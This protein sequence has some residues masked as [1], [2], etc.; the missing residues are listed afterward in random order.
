METPNNVNSEAAPDAGEPEFSLTEPDGMAES[1]R[2]LRSR[3]YPPVSNA[4]LSGK[5]RGQFSLISVMAMIFFVALGL[6]GRNWMPASVFAGLLGLLT[7]L[8]LLWVIVR[9]PE[10]LAVRLIWW[11]II[12]AYVTAILSSFIPQSM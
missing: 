7:L 12:L 9:P 2:I 8:A 5:G 1:E 6:A 11:G 4:V 3:V 10:S